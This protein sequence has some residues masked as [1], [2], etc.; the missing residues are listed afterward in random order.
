M[1]K[2]L[3]IFAATGLVLLFMA[4]CLL[5][6]CSS[7]KEQFVYYDKTA[8]V[9][10]LMDS[11]SAKA[12]WPTA[13]LLRLGISL[14]SSQERLRSG[15]Y[16]L[17]GVNVM[18]LF[19]NIRNG[20][21]Q[22]L[23]L[24]I[25]VLHTKE[26]LAQLLAHQL[27]ASETEFLSAFSD[28]L[29]LDSLGV[30]PETAVCLFV[31]NSYEVYW[32]TAPEALLARMKKESN[33]FWTDERL[34]LADS[35]GLSPNEVITLASIVE[36]ETAAKQEKATIAGLYLNRLR[37]QMPLQADPTVKFAAG[38]FALR[39]ISGSV[40]KTDSPYNTYRH[41]GLPPGPI[42]LPSIESID[43]VLNAEH[44][45]YIYMCANPDFTRTHLFSETYAQHL[46][47]A[48]QY[49]RA[50]DERGIKH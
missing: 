48:A 24:T 35:Q 29:L 11:V 47:I 5:H 17:S 20:N 9:D 30:T 18:Q 3:W 41:T 12:S 45:S 25:P 1:K 34:R 33:R 40:L 49:A 21:Q 31:P 2:Y 46:K 50:L 23:L 44:H 19:R 32:N 8:G 15:R 22:P 4:Y 14:T 28:T 27:Q 10:A 42:C 43:A 39:R 37:K 38:D 7:E 13:S 16:A 6:P 36:Q 26:Q